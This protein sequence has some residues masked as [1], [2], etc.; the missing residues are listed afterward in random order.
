MKAGRKNRDELYSVDVV[1]EVI[2][3][4]LTAQQTDTAALN[5]LAA[6]DNALADDPDLGIP[7]TILWAKLTGW[8]Q[9][10]GTLDVG[11]A[12]RFEAAVEVMAR[13]T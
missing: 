8:E 6:V 2:G 1:C 4:G 9:V 13:L 3:E 7:D 10:A 11:Y 5:L 12:C